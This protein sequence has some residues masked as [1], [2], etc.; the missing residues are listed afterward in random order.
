MSVKIVFYFYWLSCSQMPQS[1]VYPRNISNLA[2]KIKSKEP[3]ISLKLARGH[4]TFKSFIPILF[5]RQKITPPPPYTSENRYLD[6]R[7]L[8]SQRLG[9]LTQ[10]N[11]SIQ[12]QEG[13]YT[14][15]NEKMCQ[16][17]K[18]QNRSQNMPLA[19]WTCHDLRTCVH[20]VILW[21]RSKS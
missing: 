3:K 21:I 1:T 2:L 15:I 8:G 11:R 6:S 19:G 18:L 4:N 7:I 10:E 16:Q 20:E 14:P 9:I 17:I 13:K 12:S 5:S